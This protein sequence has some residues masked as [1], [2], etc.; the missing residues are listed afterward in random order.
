[1]KIIVGLGNPGKKYEKTRHNVG[2]LVLDRLLPNKKTKWNESKKAKA[3]YY[4][5]EIN[6]K[7]VELLKPNNF[8]NNSGYSV[9]YAVK[10]HNLNLKNDLIIV[11]DDKDIAL[12]KVKVQTDHGAA[13]HNGIKSI[14]QHLGT[15]NFIRVRVGIA[16]TTSPTPSF[17]K[18]RQI[19]NTAVFV[20]KKFGIFERK[21]LNEGINF[22]V[23]E[24]FKLL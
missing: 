11:H 3:L 21:K 18:R 4:K 10:K 5:T 6:G 14:I 23:E 15:Q 7:Q 9:A 8:M 17:V 13:G 16:P 24:I 19:K 20:L 1:M 2:W 22:A 12:G